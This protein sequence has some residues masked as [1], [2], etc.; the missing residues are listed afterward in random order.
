MGERASELNSPYCRKYWQAIQ[1]Y[2]I[3]PCHTILLTLLI[4]IYLALPR[5]YLGDR[6]SLAF[7]LCEMGKSPIIDP[8][9]QSRFRDS[10]VIYYVAVKAQILRNLR[11]YWKFIGLFQHIYQ[12]C[13]LKAVSQENIFSPIIKNYVK[14]T[15]LC[16]LCIW[17]DFKEY[18]DT[19]LAFPCFN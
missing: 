12:N 13:S 17:L 16:R 19:S 6:V 18:G 9:I 4:A 8:N 7:F 14:E 1:T 3:W 15:T 10:S 11:V 5:Y 2:F